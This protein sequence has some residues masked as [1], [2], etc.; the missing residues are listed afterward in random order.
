MDDIKGTMQEGTENSP[1][2][3]PT[4]QDRNTVHG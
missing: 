2:E 3:V 4:F 1:K